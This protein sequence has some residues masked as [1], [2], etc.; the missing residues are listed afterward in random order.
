MATTAAFAMSV[1]RH[2]AQD[3]RSA[4]DAGALTE[5]DIAALVST[6]SGELATSEPNSN[7]AAV[8]A[9]PP[10]IAPDAAALPVE[11][12][13]NGTTTPPAPAPVATSVAAAAP[14]S[15][16]AAPPVP[17]PASPAPL[18]TSPPS[19]TGSPTVTAHVTRSTKTV[20]SS[21]VSGIQTNEECVEAFTK[22][23][24]RKDSKFLVFYIDSKLGQV[25]LEHKGSP[26][27]PFEAFQE[28][29]P[30]AEPRYLVYDFAYTNADGCIFDKLLFI[31]WS[32]DA[33]PIKKKM[34]YA[35]TKDYFKTCLDG[36]QL[37]MQVTD[38]DEIEYEA[39]ESRVRDTLTRK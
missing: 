18:P 14:P 21:S 31:L 26:D 6:F 30:E 7:G 34:M 28:Q 22:L 27:A 3:L 2:L 20:G 38:Y 12:G 29:L 9:G 33:S 36:I 23:K 19:A 35:S 10:D 37:E 4:Y 16:A 11:A 1:T 32:P 25:C 13:V 24:K 17:L 5:E 39:I 15:D 8:A